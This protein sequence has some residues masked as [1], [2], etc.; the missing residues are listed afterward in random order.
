MISENH[1]LGMNALHYAI[2]LMVHLV[3]VEFINNIDDRSGIIKYL[4]YYLANMLLDC[5]VR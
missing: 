1:A 4:S 2:P 3:P 5:I